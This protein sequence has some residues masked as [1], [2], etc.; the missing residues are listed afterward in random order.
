M[1]G[2]HHR[3]ARRLTGRQPRQGRD[4][5]WV[6]HPP[7]E[8]AVDARLKEVETYVSRRHNKVTKF[9]E[10]IPIIYLYLVAE[11][12]PGSRVTKRLW[13]QDGL[14]VEGIRMA[15]REAE[16]MEWEEETDETETETD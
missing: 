12:R 6:Y 13:E 2:F 9:I 3:V 16:R 15:D 5:V 7:E 8:T 10:N 4:S 1:G 11:Q 14:D